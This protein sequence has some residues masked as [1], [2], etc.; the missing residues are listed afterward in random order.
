MRKSFPSKILRIRQ[1]VHSF[2]KFG[3]VDCGATCSF[4]RKMNDSVTIGSCA[5]QNSVLLFHMFFN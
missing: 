2:D 3:A 4:P 1:I 5:E